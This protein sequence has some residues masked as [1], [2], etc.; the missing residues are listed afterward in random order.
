MRHTALRLGA[1][2][3]STEFWRKKKIRPKH[4]INY[5]LLHYLVLNVSLLEYRRQSCF[6]PH[7]ASLPAASSGS[8]S[9]IWAPRSQT[10][11]LSDELQAR[12]D[13]LSSFCGRAKP[14]PCS[15]SCVA[16]SGITW[17]DGTKQQKQEHKFIIYLYIMLILRHS[18][19]KQ[20]KC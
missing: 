5:K 11:L 13:T 18:S 3:F 4:D 16:A 20:Y 1:V 19:N 12:A 6:S 9:H 17:T 2:A 15:L 8:H 7:S 10:A 14:T